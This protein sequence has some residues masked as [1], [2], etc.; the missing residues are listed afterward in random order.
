MIPR[1]TIAP[2]RLKRPVTTSS[3]HRSTKDR[4][5]PI[6]SNNITHRNA[7]VHKYHQ[8]THLGH[9]LPHDYDDFDGRERKPF[10]NT[11]PPNAPFLLPGVRT[12]D[13]QRSGFK[14][15]ENATLRGSCNFGATKPLWFSC[16]QSVSRTD[17]VRKTTRSVKTLVSRAL[18][19]RTTVRLDDDPKG[20]SSAVID[21][22]RQ[23]RR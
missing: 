17:T 12:I 14:G 22:I 1:N 11:L 10:P 4:I 2:P 3:G 23:T 6:R 16:N 20:R 7:N 15:K 5:F 19:P 13:R 21:Y 18:K 8:A 9:D